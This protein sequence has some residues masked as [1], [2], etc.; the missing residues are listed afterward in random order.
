MIDGLGALGVAV[1]RD[2]ATSTLTVEGTAGHPVSDVALVDARLSGTTSRFLLP[3]AAL[4][5]GLRRV[6]G[7]GR[8]R[9]RP[10]GPALD[11][12]RALG[13]DVHDVG[14]PGHLPVELVGGTLAG[15]EVAISGDVSSQFLPGPLLAA[16]ATRPGLPVRVPTAPGARPDSTEK[17]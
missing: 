3:L 14:G 6:D 7:A 13:A 15:G 10:M 5:D 16:P 4:G 17:R 1:E 9:E 11:A 12:L 8:L 2:W